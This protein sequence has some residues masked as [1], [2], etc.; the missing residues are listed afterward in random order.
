MI[1]TVTLNPAIDTQYRLENFSINNVNRVAS[2]EKTPGGKGLNVSRVLNK[3][4]GKLI[5]TGFLGMNNANFIEDGLNNLNIA[6]DFLKIPG[7]TRT[8]IAIQ[9]GNGSTELLEKGPNVDS[10]AWNEFKVKF[11]NMLSD[12]KVICASGSLPK[13][14]PD[15][16]YKELIELS[17]DKGI[18]FILDSSGSSLKASLEAN[19]FLIKPNREE[20]EDLFNVELTGLDSIIEC[21]KKLQTL[22]AKNIMI[23]LG[24]DGAILITESKV[25]QGIIPKIEVMNTVGS[26]DSSI[27]G[28]AFG[29]QQGLELQD[30][31]KLALACGSSNAMLPTTGDIQLET[32]E[33]LRNE[34][35]IKEI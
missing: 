28:F 27:G 6:N 25:Y 21:G 23:T 8:C 18:K 29:L 33:K 1:L 14:L 15:T 22:G 2:V 16:A 30:A 12:T 17:K 19:P 5:A 32:V 4:Q 13:G 10:Q 11:L 24:G 3:L 9:D 26:G 34:I 7:D 35:E 31:F 20:L